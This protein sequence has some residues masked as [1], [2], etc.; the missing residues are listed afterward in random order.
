MW[1]GVVLYLHQE[2]NS[3]H[4]AEIDNPKDKA[5]RLSHRQSDLGDLSSILLKQKKQ[6]DSPHQSSSL[7]P[8]LFIVFSLWGLRLSLDFVSE[9]FWSIRFF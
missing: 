2:R 3:E 7:L 6:R 1:S 8:Y 4:A 5:Q 9:L